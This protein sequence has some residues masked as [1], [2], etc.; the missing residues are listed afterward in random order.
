ML[1]YKEGLV[2]RKCSA[3][4]PAGIITNGK[5]DTISLWKNCNFLS[6]DAPQGMLEMAGLRA[7]AVVGSGAGEVLRSPRGLAALTQPGVLGLAV[8]GL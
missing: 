7:G 3:V 4:V 1:S 5:Y 6:A 2:A 8:G